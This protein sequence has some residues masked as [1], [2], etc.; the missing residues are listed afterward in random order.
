MSKT[1]KS[2]ADVQ[3]SE[4][5]SEGSKTTEQGKRQECASVNYKRFDRLLTE[6]QTIASRDCKGF[7]SGRDTQNGVLESGTD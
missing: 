1:R 7:G 4:Q 5:V 2:L 6:A 3:P